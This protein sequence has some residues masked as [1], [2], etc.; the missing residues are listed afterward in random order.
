MNPH[1]LADELALLVE[2][3]ASGD[4]FAASRHATRLLAEAAFE[5]AEQ[6][7]WETINAHQ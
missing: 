1:Y 5:A 7:E 6:D 2:E 4:E 3:I